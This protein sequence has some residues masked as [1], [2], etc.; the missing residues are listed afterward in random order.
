MTRT[1]PIAFT[2][3]FDEY[4][5]NRFKPIFRILHSS[6]ILCMLTIPGVSQESTWSTLSNSPL[7]KGNRTDDIYFINDSTGWAVNGNGEIF[8]TRDSGKSW[9]LQFKTTTYFR[10][11]EFINDTTG[12]VGSL[13]GEA[14]KTTDAGVT[15]NRI[16]QHFPQTV[17]GI[18][19]ISHFKNSIVMAGI[20]NSPAY[21]LTSPDGGITWAHQDMS[22]Y[23]SAL[24]DCWYKSEDS[25]FVSGKGKAGEGIILLSG[26]KGM[27]WQKASPSDVPEGTTW[28]LQ[29][30]TASIGYASVFEGTGTKSH[31]LKTTDGGLTFKLIKILNRN[32]SMEGIGF[33]NSTTGWVGGWSRGM[34]ETRDGGSTWK[35][36]D[37]NNNVNR[38]FILNEE[39]AY[40]AGEQIYIYEKT[41]SP[42]TSVL[43][44]E[45]ELIHTI[46]T[47][48]NPSS[49]N[50]KIRV[51]LKKST[52][53]VLELYDLNGKSVKRLLNGFFSA[54]EFV[55]EIMPGDFRSGIYTA[56]IYTNENSIV[57]KIFIR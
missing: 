14:Y 28:K 37:A 8:S 42:V 54:G 15:W 40:A 53:V 55:H 2:F 1:T 41:E 50:I 10:T 5:Y 36:L 7:L 3:L 45:N 43:P 12:F 39:L 29:F 23:A 22:E 13:R 33:I 47:Y 34:Y 38:Y 9:N 17:K 16:D 20:W 4:R 24:V 49:E 19:G 26:D 25:V 51:N 48:P 44:S 56:V 57:Q 31:I 21:V 52:Y 35:Y 6:M 30:V 46:D 18:C 11:V 32:I 27:T